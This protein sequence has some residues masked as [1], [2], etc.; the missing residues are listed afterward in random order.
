VATLF[1][2]V[3]NLLFLLSTWV[4]F[5]PVLFAQATPDSTRHRIGFRPFIAPAALVAGGLVTVGR[6]SRSVQGEVL[7]RYPNGLNTRVDDVLPFA[8]TL[9][10]LGLGVAGVEGKHRLKDQLILTVLSH[11]LART[12]TQG[13]KYTVQYPRP[14]GEEHE[15]FPSGHTSAAFTSA[16]LLAN[17]YGGRSAWYSVGGYGAATTVGAFRVLKNRH[18]LADVLVGAGVGIGATEGVYALYP[19]LQRTLFKSKT[20]AFLPTYTGYSAGFCWV[21]VF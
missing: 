19:W 13:L 7:K 1:I 17:E 12:I 20:S 14:D 9:V 4:L 5:Q 6:L 15:S 18:W 11:G 2:T 21:T 10:M 16:T 8:P 3:R